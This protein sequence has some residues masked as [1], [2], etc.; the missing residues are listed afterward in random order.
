MLDEDDSHMLNEPLFL[1]SIEVL[2]LITIGISVLLL[3]PDI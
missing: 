2:Y 1:L 3:I